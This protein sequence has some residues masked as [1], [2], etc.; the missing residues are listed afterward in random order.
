MIHAINLSNYEVSTFFS[1]ESQIVDMIAVGD[2]IYVLTNDKKIIFLY[3]TTQQ[4]FIVNTIYQVCLDFFNF[5]YF[6]ILV[7]RDTGVEHLQNINP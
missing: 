4:K 2:V 5:I 6:L 7:S 3:S 1:F